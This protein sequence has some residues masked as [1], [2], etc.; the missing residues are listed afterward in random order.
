M[1][2]SGNFTTSYLRV[3]F[4]PSLFLSAGLIIPGE[5]GFFNKPD[6]QAFAYLRL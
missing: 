2:L 4:W 1:N 3:V 6:R 5:G